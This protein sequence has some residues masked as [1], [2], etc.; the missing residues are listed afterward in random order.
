MAPKLPWLA[1]FPDPFQ[2]PL[3]VLVVLNFLFFFVFHL[4]VKTTGNINN[5]ARAFYFIQYHNVRLVVFNLVVGLYLKFHSSLLLVDWYPA[6][7]SW[8]F[9]SCHNPA[10][11]I[12]PNES[13]APPCRASNINKNCFWASFLHSDTLWLTVSSP[14]PY[15]LLIFADTFLLLIILLILLVILTIISHYYYNYHCYYFFFIIIITLITGC[16]AEGGCIV[17]GH[18]MEIHL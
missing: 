14:S 6:C 2:L 9:H 10:F 18:L 16:L 12:G 15:I 17:G 13:S 5:Q 7:G 4:N 8:F 1:Q 11:H 3:Q